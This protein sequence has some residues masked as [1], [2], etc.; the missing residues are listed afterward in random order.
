MNDYRVSEVATLLNCTKEIV[1]K[2]IKAG[3]L[4][5][6]KIGKHGTRI[7]REELDRIRGCLQ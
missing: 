7:R 1:Y 2:L 5:C 3:T 6:Y 4:K